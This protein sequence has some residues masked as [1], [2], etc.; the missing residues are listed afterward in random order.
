[1]ADIKFDRKNLYREETITDLKV[2][3]IQR[4]TPIKVDGTKDQSRPHLFVGQTQ[5]LSQSGPVPVSS[6]IEA[7]TL[8]EAIRLFPET[9][10]KAVE[11][12]VDEVKQ[13]QREQMGRIVVPGQTPGG[14]K[15]IT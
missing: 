7:E 13:L 11:R 1:M 15:I 8:E 10:Q 2:G 4:L 14:P 9:M 6:R 12:L 5:L 3:T